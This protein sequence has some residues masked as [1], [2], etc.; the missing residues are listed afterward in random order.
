MDIQKHI[1]DK[2]GVMLPISGGN[3]HSQEQAV[4][5]ISSKYKHMF[6]EVQNDYISLW[7]DAGRWRKVG[8]S[9]I[10]DDDDGSKYDKI[11]IHQYL[12]D[13]KGVEKIFWFDITNCFGI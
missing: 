13:E 4:V 7:L 11:S 6:I 9:L 5:I 3:G 2:T 10:V 1:I 8:Q 12:D